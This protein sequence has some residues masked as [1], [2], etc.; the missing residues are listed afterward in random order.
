MA[1][2]EVRIPRLLEIARLAVSSE[3]PQFAEWTDPRPA[4]QA[5]LNNLVSRIDADVVV[6]TGRYP[7]CSTAWV[8]FAPSHGEY[9]PRSG[10]KIYPI[11]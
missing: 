2:T 7:R 5:V 4:D 10:K 1:L 8:C 3:H 9:K 6:T 11:K